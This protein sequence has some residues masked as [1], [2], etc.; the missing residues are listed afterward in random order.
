MAESKRRWPVAL[1]MGLLTLALFLA[2]GVPAAR[3]GQPTEDIKQLMDEVLTVLGNA[4]LKAPAQKRR[5]LELIE[6]LAASRFDYRE[7]ARISLEPTWDKLT[8]AQQDEFV[9]LFT[10]LLKVSYAD[11]IDEIA[12]ARVEYQPEKLMGD[13]A[14]VSAVILRPNDRIP[15]DFCLHQTPRGWMIY[16]LIIEKVSL[17]ENFQHEFGRAIEGASFNYLL[18]CLK[19]KLAAEKRD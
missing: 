9:R 10:E 18:G 11:R 3:A 8:K 16:D 14:Q 4:T 19:G 5:R 13:K 7:M 2:P 6:N 15:V 1:T 12:N 17:A